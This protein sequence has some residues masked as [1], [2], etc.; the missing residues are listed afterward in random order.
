MKSLQHFE[1]CTPIGTENVRIEEGRVKGRWSL[2]LSVFS[3]F[4]NRRLIEDFANWSDTPEEIVR[5]TRMYG[6]LDSD[7]VEGNDFEFSVAGWRGT[8]QRFRLM[9]ES[10]SG[11]T[12][13]S[14]TFGGLELP[15]DV[16][17]RAGKLTFFAKRLEGFLLLELITASAE[18]LRKCERPGCETPYFVARHLKQVYCSPRCAAWAQSQWKEKWWKDRGSNWLAERKKRRVNP[19]SKAKKQTEAMRKRGEK[20]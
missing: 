17:F 8:Q 9:W 14:T 10:R 13:L 11:K 4:N 16:N 15:Y 12:N 20:Q 18:H 5:F 1:F 6:P 3:G 7:A 19:K 2:K